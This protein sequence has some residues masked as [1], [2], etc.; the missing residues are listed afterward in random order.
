MDNTATLVLCIDDE[1]LGLKVRRMVLEHAGY[2]VLTASS[3]EEGLEVFAANPV[4]LVVLDYAMPGLTGGEVAARMRQ[5]K[6]EVPI[7]LLS[8][9]VDLG[10]E[11]ASLVDTYMVKGIGA[12]ALLAALASILANR[13]SQ[14]RRSGATARNA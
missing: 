13:T 9:Y 7:I 3:G 12:A 8:A 14:S 1:T 2:Q 6:P 4:E 10:P 11:V 5:I